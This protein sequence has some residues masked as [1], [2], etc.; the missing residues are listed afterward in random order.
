MDIQMPKMDGIEAT[1]KLRDLGYQKPIIAYTGY[2]INVDREYFVAAGFDDYADK[3]SPTSKIVTLVD[4]YFRNQ[5]PA[6]HSKA[7]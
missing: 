2:K 7:V 3:D 5:T 1:H 4:Q 6:S